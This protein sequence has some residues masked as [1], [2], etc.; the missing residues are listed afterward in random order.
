MQ[1]SP[2]IPSVSIGISVA[3]VTALFPVSDAMIPSKEP[4][5]NSSGSLDARWAS[6]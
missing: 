6:L 3:P 4:F 1:E 2:G 5:P